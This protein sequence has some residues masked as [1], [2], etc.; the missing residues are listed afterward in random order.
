MIKE[1]YVYYKL[2]LIL[3]LHLLLVYVGRLVLKL[4]KRH[5]NSIVVM[6][7]YSICSRSDG[8]PANYSQ[9]VRQIYSYLVS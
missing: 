1:H 2:I 4:A 5:A 9:S 6:D 8:Q 7:Y 3:I